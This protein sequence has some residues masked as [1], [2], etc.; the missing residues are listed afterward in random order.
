MSKFRVGEKVI[1]KPGLAGPLSRVASFGIIQYHIEGDA[2]VIVEWYDN[3]SLY[4]AKGIY[5]ESSLESIEENLFEKF[6][7]EKSF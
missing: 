2:S 3:Y 4:K 7:D 5:Y 1:P 6:Y